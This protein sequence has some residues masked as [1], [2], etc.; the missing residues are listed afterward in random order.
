[1]V[2]QTFWASVAALPLS[3][4]FTVV[5]HE[6]LWFS[7]A[8]CSVCSMLRVLLIAYIVR[9]YFRETTIGNWP[10]TNACSRC[11]SSILNAWQHDNLKCLCKTTKIAE[12]LTIRQ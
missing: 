9:L 4:S 2:F 6:R 1:M 10:K 12:R 11:G 3:R 8:P 7:T 5:Y